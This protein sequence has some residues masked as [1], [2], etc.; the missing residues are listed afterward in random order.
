MKTLLKV[1]IVRCIST[2][3]HADKHNPYTNPSYS[4][5]F[6]QNGSHDNGNSENSNGHQGEGNHGVGLGNQQHSVPTIPLPAAVWL[7]GTTMM[8]YLYSIRN[9]N[10]IA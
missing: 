8:G 7:F 5:V 10:R 2:A 4:D 1:L 9:R 3:V 6:Q